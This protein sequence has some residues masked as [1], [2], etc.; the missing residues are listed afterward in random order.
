[1]EM[2]NSLTNLL[3]GLEISISANYVLLITGIMA[4]AIIWGK[5]KLGITAVAGASAVW[6]LQVNQIELMD[7]I[8]GSSV[9]MMA[10]LSV[11]LGMSL[12]IMMVFKDESY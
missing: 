2:I 3:S 8:H 9:G 10:A 11:V 7:F 6:A 12:L 5:K 1:M 4:L